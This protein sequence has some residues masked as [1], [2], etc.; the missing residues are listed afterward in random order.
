MTSTYFIVMYT[1][2]YLKAHF[3]FVLMLFVLMLFV[4]M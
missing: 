1:H 4:L 2:G 3:I